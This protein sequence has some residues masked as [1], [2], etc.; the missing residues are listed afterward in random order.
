MNETILIIGSETLLGRKL[1]ELYLDNSYRV[2]APAMA[3]RE[4]L[5]ATED[6]NLLVTPWNR[7]SIISSKTVIREAVRNFK[8]IEETIVVNP[9]LAESQILEDTDTETLDTVLNLY[10]RGT[11][12]LV[13]EVVG[14][15]RK[16][17]RGV[18]A[19][20]E[21][22]KGLHPPFM[23]PALVRGAFH[24][25]A[26]SLLYSREED[27]LRCAFTSRLTEMED[28]ARFIKKILESGNPRI[29]GK[30]LRFSEKKNL[31]QTLPIIKK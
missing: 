6:K 11:L 21:T 9:E 30:W 1:V 26:E 16:Q 28:Y 25:M 13:K 4:D 24:G 31:F 3:S 12:Y 27:I 18:L 22:E 14:C 23:L 8:T 5:K 19:F 17:K 7:E 2:I 20:A 10:I 29:K 15:Y